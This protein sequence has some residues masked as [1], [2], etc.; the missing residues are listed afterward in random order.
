MV[1][2]RVAGWWRMGRDKREE[3]REGE[4]GRHV[5]IRAGL[6]VS[7]EETRGNRKAQ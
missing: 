1:E 2:E 4:R 3:Q 7:I 6:I 5:K